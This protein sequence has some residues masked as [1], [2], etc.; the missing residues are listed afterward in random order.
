MNKNEHEL[1]IQNNQNRAGIT[2]HPEAFL[3]M[4]IDSAKDY[5]IF[6]MDLDRNV[7]F[8]NTGAERMFGYAEAE[9]IGKLGD[10]VFTPEDRAG[11]VPLAEAAL[12]LQQGFAQDDRWHIRKDGTRI[13]VSG[14]TR[15]I[16][17]DQR[18]PQGFIKVARDITERV[19]I[20]AAEREQRALAEALRDTATAINASL[21]LPEVLVLI[22]ENVKRVVEYD[23]AYII[24]FDE[25]KISQIHSKG[26]AEHGLGN[27]ETALGQLENPFEI[28]PQWQ[29]LISSREPIIIVDTHDS[30][31]TQWQD[32]FQSGLIRSFAGVPIVNQDQLH[33]L[34]GLHSLTQA[35]F[36]DTHI[37]R[38]TIFATQAALAIQNAQ[39]HEMAQQAAV[40]GERS[41]LSR[42]LHDSVTQ[43]LF[44]SSVLS[45]T[46]PRQLNDPEKLLKTAAD[47]ERLNR[48]ALA[49]MRRL[50]REL[51]MR[52]ITSVKLRDLLN[53]LALIAMGNS[54][55]T[56]TTELEEPPVLP[57]EVHEA[58]YRVTQEALNNLIKHSE[59]SAATI[60]L[61]NQENQ[62]ILSIQDN[63]RGFKPQ[64]VG[65]ESLGLGIM[66]ERVSAINALLEIKSEP[67]KGTEI[68]V[69]WS[70]NEGD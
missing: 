41:R 4:M 53:Q 56:I 7:T 32:P 22:L 13:F 62:L 36:T 12:A 33:G 44:A 20:E 45:G 46:L 11:G 10:V 59:A 15:L 14:M 38:L 70:K 9:I 37:E 63:G 49:E 23:A 5:A 51:R 43:M 68:I 67:D 26:Y 3:E 19:R 35:A 65:T 1:P 61:N 27:L 60:R 48:G 34:F 16:T 28:L 31:P 18:A 24:L 52:D 47:L 54:P 50:L 21:N 55:I 8:W 39:L 40:I 42:D 64:T 25:Q 17:H 6:A 29:S 57:P 2:A 69:A 66:R 30:S 58:F